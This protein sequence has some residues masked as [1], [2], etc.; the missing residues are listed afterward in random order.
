MDN[1]TSSS[2]GGGS[3]F[4]GSSGGGDFGGLNSNTSDV[5]RW[6]NLGSSFKWSRKWTDKLYSNSLLS[7][8]NYY[9]NR[10]NSRNISITRDSQT[11]NIK[12]GQ[13]EDNNLTDLTAKMDFEYKLTPHHQL[14]F[15]LQYTLNRIEYSYSQND[16]I[17]VLDRDDRG[18]TLT[19][20]VQDQINLLDGKIQLK[21]GLRLTHFDVTNK[22][23]LEPRF[24]ANY[25][26]ND[27]IKLKAATSIYTK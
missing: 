18:S 8:S 1:S 16:T 19:A 11:T 26:L 17:K 21:P 14:D 23:Y 3:P 13:I 9:S 27:R 12:I 20:Y 6:G 7:Y 22:N 24:S 10:D 15:G 2:F 5:S 25:Q 4:G